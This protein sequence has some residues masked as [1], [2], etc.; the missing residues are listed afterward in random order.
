VVEGRK[1]GRPRGRRINLDSVKALTES[2]SG[3]NLG[4]MV[5]DVQAQL[6]R[7]GVHVTAQ[8]LAVLQA[9][10]LTPHA[11]VEEL[12]SSV[13]SSIG[14]ISRQSVYDTLSLLVEKGIIRRIQPVGSPARFED[15]VGDNHHH[16]VCRA[17]GH[18]A[19]VDCA[20][21]Y[22]PC[23]TPSND[24]SYEVDEAEVVYWGICPTCQGNRSA[25]DSP[26]AA[27]A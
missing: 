1:S 8:R 4:F 20:V 11:T 3:G 5:P 22:T 9:V 14:S 12:T 17:C 24:W 15:R 19:D 26:I 16:L 27:Q 23:L 10:A 21:G 2:K 6:R 25:P 13:R 18:L 7:H